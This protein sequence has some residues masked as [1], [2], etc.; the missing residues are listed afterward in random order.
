M[1][2]TFVPDNK[3]HATVLPREHALHLNQNDQLSQ[4]HTT[5]LSQASTV[6]EP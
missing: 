4:E 5:E 3:A 1:L 6:G 2:G